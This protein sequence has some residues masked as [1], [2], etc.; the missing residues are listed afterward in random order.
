MEIHEYPKRLFVK[1]DAI[2][3]KVSILFHIVDTVHLRHCSI[4]FHNQH[5]LQYFYNYYTTFNKDF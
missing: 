3:K 2:L 5:C 1:K 4:L